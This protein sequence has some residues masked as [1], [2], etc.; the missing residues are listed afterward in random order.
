MIALGSTSTLAQ[1][2]PQAAASTF[3]GFYA[4]NASNGVS[5]ADIQAVRQ[6]GGGR[7]QVLIDWYRIEPTIWHNDSGFNGVLIA[8]VDQA[9][10][11]IVNAGLEPVLLIA[12]PPPWAVATPDTQGPIL[13]SARSRYIMFVRRIVERYGAAPFNARYIVLA[14]EPD[15]RGTCASAPNHAAWGDVPSEFATLLAQTYAA[16]KA[17]NSAI[18]II[19]GAFAYDYFGG[20]GAPG[21]NGG[22]CFNYTFIDSLLAA[23]AASYFDVFAFNAYAVFSPGWEANSTGYDVAAKAA[24]LRARFPTLASKPFMVLEAG[25]W[26]DASV[27]VPV[28][29]ADGSTAS[30]IPDQV[31]QAGYAGKLLARALSANISTVLWYGLRDA[32]GD[33]QRGMYDQSGQAKRL[34]TALQQATSRLR[35][36]TYLSTL[37]T[38][39]NADGA[40]EGYLFSTTSGGRMAVLWA[41][42]G[43]GASAT[44]TFDLVGGSIRAFDFE[45]SGAANYQVSGDAVTIT[46]GPTPM[47]V[48]TGQTTLR[49]FIPVSPRLSGNL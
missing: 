30:V 1:R 49:T 36:T 8:P 23:G 26:S 32:S 6:V 41:V 15:A 3:F 16:V 42:G 5:S 35:S 38:R 17:D 11:D 34:Y 13:A 31:W 46:V 22:G 7:V 47:Y 20:A 43:G 10:T 14:P 2:A 39:G 18:Q 25:V 12:N 48:V 21:F 45:G 9:M 33:V 28:R 19:P 24:Y 27:A 37:S 4:W 40:V 29:N 44:T